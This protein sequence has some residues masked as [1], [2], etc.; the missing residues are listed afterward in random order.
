MR[1][2]IGTNRKKTP[3]MNN[4][5][6]IAILV[7][8]ITFTLMLCSL[9]ST[10][11]H[12]QVSPEAIQVES[13]TS[14]NDGLLKAPMIISQAAIVGGVFNHMFLQR[15][16][17]GT[18]QSNYKNNKPVDSNSLQ[19][20]RRLFILLIACSLT[21]LVAASSLIYL[22]T[23]SLSS[24]LDLDVNTTFTILTSTSVGPV[25]ILRIITSSII[26]I[27]SILYYIIEKKKIKSTTEEEYHT[28]NKQR[29]RNL[30]LSIALLYV[31]MLSGAI[32]ILSNSIVS[33]SAALSFLPSLAVSMNWL[34]FMA[35]SI[36]VGGL[37]YISAI[38]LVTIRSVIN[39][40]EP[41]NEAYETN[42]TKNTYFLA[43]LLPYFSLIATLS[44][45]I[46][47]VTGLYMAWTHLHTAAALF[48]TQYGNILI[49][50]LSAILPMVILGGYHQLR[51]HD[52]LVL[53]AKIG[54]GGKK[55]NYERKSGANTAG[56]SSNSSTS[57]RTDPF[58]KFSKTIKI[59]S[60]IGIGVLF[61]TSFLT[62]TS[63][64]SI[65]MA[66]NSHLNGS[67]AGENGMPPFDS[68]A[69]LIIILST[70]VLTG[71]VVYFVKS[72]REIKKTIDSLHP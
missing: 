12:A 6:I 44:L 21:I 8:I 34:H 42:K 50:K 52:S 7:S 17:R 31:I 64:P 13:V 41:T 27:S 9:P 71:S 46:I 33:H 48:D 25:W 59:E 1:N 58:T 60:F 40:T 47:G 51:L 24:E 28:Y 43:V 20:L 63:P 67:S 29:K 68:F 57:V 38:L 54:D 49:I 39:V 26:V 66:E 22:Q 30:G 36:W 18:I 55:S 72:K 16:L 70:V 3:I 69:I 23:I 11:V 4:L 14:T 2:E 56:G 45:G 10:R 65:S 53:V 61:I 32:S 37:F 15:V 62:I 19:S 35:V 5:I